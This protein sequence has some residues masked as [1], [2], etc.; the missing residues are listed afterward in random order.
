M[1]SAITALQI[2]VSVFLVGAVLLQTK[3]GGLGSSFGQGQ[4]MFRTKRG[5]ERILHLS[6]IFLGCL[7]FVVSILSVLV[8]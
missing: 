6:T 7:F 3:G 5:M 4:E 1:S 2:L 8:K